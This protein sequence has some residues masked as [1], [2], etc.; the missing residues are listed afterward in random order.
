MIVDGKVTIVFVAAVLERKAQHALFDFCLFC[1]DM[2]G[3][4][5]TGRR[6]ITRSVN[7]L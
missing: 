3:D 2:F 6:F 4:D 5:C 7:Q 1:S